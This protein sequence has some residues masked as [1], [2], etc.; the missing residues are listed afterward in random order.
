MNDEQLMTDLATI[1]MDWIADGRTATSREK[2]LRRMVNTATRPDTD[3]PDLLQVI[4][5]EALLAGKSPVTADQGR[6][7]LESEVLRRRFP[8]QV[9]EEA[10]SRDI[11]WHPALISAEPSTG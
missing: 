2:R 7:I 3:L 6:R 8:F 4:S 9:L 1:C 11:A 5:V 10:G